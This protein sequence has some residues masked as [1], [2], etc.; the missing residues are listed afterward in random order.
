MIDWQERIAIAVTRRF[1][2]AA[3]RA[4]CKYERSES[5]YDHDDKC[6]HLTLSQCAGR[7]VWIT[8]SRPVVAFK[9]WSVATAITPAA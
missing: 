1:V 6:C 3:I 5:T 9:P 2:A 8:P 4:T 7:V